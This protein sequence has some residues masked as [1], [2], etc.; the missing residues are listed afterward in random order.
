VT[1][2]GQKGVVELLVENGADVNAQNDRGDTPLV[3]LVKKRFDLL[4]TY[5]IRQG[6]DH[7][8]ENFEGFSARD[9]ALEFLQAEL[10]AA[11]AGALPEGA[12]EAKQAL[13]RATAELAGAKTPVR[14]PP[15]PEQVKVA[16]PAAGQQVMRIFF[17]S[18][19]YKT[20]L[21]GPGDSARDL[22]YKMAKKINMADEAAYFDVMNV[23]ATEERR[24]SPQELILD[25]K[26]RYHKGADDNFTVLLKRG[27]PAPVVETFKK[28]T[29]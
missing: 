28:N 25:V 19:G 15:K 23:C 11:A 7:N 21:V 24:L 13:E 1:A 22:A 29:K 8:L 6:A 14:P 26:A 3:S 4:A 16:A 5:L 18:G 17:R 2:K 20:L 27:T 12:L 10:D 9:Y